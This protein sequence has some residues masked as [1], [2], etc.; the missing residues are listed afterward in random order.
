MNVANILAVANAIETSSI[1]GLGFNMNL[2]FGH[3]IALGSYA[4]DTSGHNCGTTACIG[5]WTRALAIGSLNEGGDV[6]SD[7]QR[8]L[9]LDYHTAA[10]LMMPDAGGDFFE[11]MLFRNTITP[12]MA[13]RCLRNLAI[14]GK[15]DW[16]AAMKPNDPKLPALPKPVAPLA[17]EHI[18]F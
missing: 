5:G 1:P 4:P 8:W 15:V 10:E 6:F 13:V 16:D 17:A 11:V 18:E 2:W 12:E 14:T 7:A 3:G 9:S